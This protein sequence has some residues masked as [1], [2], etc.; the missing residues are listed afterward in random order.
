MKNALLLDTHIALWLDSG[1][2]RLRRSTQA[3]IDGCWHGGGTII[4]SAVTTW[5]I[6]L[7]VDTGRIDLDSPVDAWVKR[8]TDVPGIEAAPLTHTAA[9]R[10]YQLHHLEHRDLADRLLIA[11]AIEFDCPLVTYD[12]RIL[13]FG[14]KHGRQYRFAIGTG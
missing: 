9:C 4:L 12:E 7:L 11:T 10:A 5:E 6:A 2:S 3:L 13:R 8:F 1:D 14:K